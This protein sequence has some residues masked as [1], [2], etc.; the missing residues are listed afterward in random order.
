MAEEKKNDQETNLKQD[1]HCFVLG[2]RMLCN[3]IVRNGKIV[4]P[5]KAKYLSFPVPF[6]KK[7]KEKTPI[8]ALILAL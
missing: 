3:Y 4:R 2:N 7:K 8:K 5:T 1:Q 6:S